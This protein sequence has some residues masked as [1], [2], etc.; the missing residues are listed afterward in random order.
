MLDEEEHASPEEQYKEIEITIKGMI[1]KGKPRGILI[2]SGP[3]LGKTTR[4][5][6]ILKEYGYEDGGKLHKVEGKITAPMLYKTLYEHRG[7]GEIIFFDDA[8]VL[9]PEASQDMTE[10]FKA[11][12]NSTPQRK[13]SYNTSSNNSLKGNTK[14]DTSNDVPTSFIYEGYIIFCTNYAPEKIDSAVRTR[15]FMH[16][17]NFSTKQLLDFIKKIMTGLSPEEYSTKVKMKAYEYLENT[18]AN[19]DSMPLNLRTF[20]T[21]LEVFNMQEADEDLTDKMVQHMVKQQL[22]L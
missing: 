3:G 15:T 4:V 18:V 7:K 16:Y 20:M 12:L 1:N 2:S 8:T 21:C 10:I 22:A 5:L 11:A 14:R 17:L 9:G 19:S 6:R 13:V